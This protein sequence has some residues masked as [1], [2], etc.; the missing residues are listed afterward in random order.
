MNLLN[1]FKQAR[2]SKDGKVLVEN[3]AY[4]S[5]LQIA[6]YIFPL[7]TIPYLARVIGVDSFGKIAFASAVI[8]YFNTVADWGFNYTA[9]RD[10]AKNRD[11]K[12]IVSKI[13]SLILWARCTLM[14][15]SF[16]VLI[17]MIICIP[18]FR[19]ISLLL[20]ITFL[21]IP[22]HIMFPD[23]FFQAMEKMKY[24]TILNLVSKFIFTIAVF[25][26]IKEKSDYLLQ[27]LF[28]ALGFFLSGII[29]MYYILV[30][31]KIKLLRPKY[32]EVRSTIKKSTDVFINNLM[33]NLYNSFSILL[34]GFF[35]GPIS[36]G[37]LDAG[38][39]FVNI[40][41]Q[42]MSM[43]SRSFFPLLSRRIDKHHIYKNINIIISLIVSILLFLVAPLLI[44]LFFTDEFN[45]SVVVLRIMAFSFLFLSFSDTY[46][47]NYMIIQGYE[48][49][50]R[51][52]TVVCSLIG[53]AI[54]FPLVYFFDFIGAAIT[55]TIARGILG[56][57]TMLKA[58][59]LSKIL[60]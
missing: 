1:K 52:I 18:Q 6:G 51:N 23:W 10:I 27:P 43:I 55:I 26:F 2:K 53:F 35:G 4:L 7:V 36:N 38:N 47:I 30:K 9:T 15:L 24:I 32:T 14:I 39:K 20:V 22:G 48:K 19:E 8:G 57:S 25:V 45:D 33:P 12:Q 28:T 44:K 37:I 21:V 13:F 59:R 40:T 56:V 49:Q 54:S 31:W 34:L 60:K 16:I 42:F 11:N 17:I 3:F 29:A 50:L 41:Q 58:R 46:G 5:L